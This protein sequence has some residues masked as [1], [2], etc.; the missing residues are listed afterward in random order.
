ME[1]FSRSSHWTIFFVPLS[2]V[3]CL[4]KV[5]AN[6]LTWQLSHDDSY[7]YEFLY[8]DASNSR[9]THDEPVSLQL[10]GRVALCTRCR[11]RPNIQPPDSDSIRFYSHWLS[12]P[13]TSIDTIFE[14]FSSSLD[15]KSQPLCTFVKEC[16]YYLNCSCG[17]EWSKKRAA[18]K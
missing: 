12:R 13:S 1:N 17:C 15:Q 10:F 11:S 5:F 2:A 9:P 6:S 4:F 8:A 7:V 14:T 16:N 18:L 3:F